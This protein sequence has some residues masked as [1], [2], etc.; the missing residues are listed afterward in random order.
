MK[1]IKFLVLL[2]IAVILILF[3]IANNQISEIRILPDNFII[4]SKVQSFYLLPLFMILYIALAVGILLGFFFEYF[5]ARKQRVKLK[6]AKRDINLLQSKI[7]KLNLKHSDG[8][9]EILNL[10]DSD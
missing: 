9:S 6:Q 7:K 5:R 1:Y 2:V 3:A 10:I 4:S 8:D